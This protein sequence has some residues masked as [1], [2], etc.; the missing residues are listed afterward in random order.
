MT[1]EAQTRPDCWDRQI[2]VDVTMGLSILPL[3]LTPLPPL[4]DLPGHL[5]RYYV[6]LQLQH[7]EALRQ[8]WDFDWHLITNL[9]FDLLVVPLAKAMGLL[10][11]T[12][13]LAALL[14]P[15]M[16]LGFFRVARAVH[17]QAPPTWL[18]AVPFA[19]SFPYHYGFVNFWLSSALALHAFASWIMARERVTHAAV[20]T[21]LLSLSCLLIWLAHLYGW[22]VLVMLVGGYEASRIWTWKL[23]AFPSMVGLVL[24]RSLPV[25]TPVF[26]LGRHA[27]SPAQVSDF[28]LAW[29]VQGLANALRD[30]YFALDL[31]TMALAACL[32][33][34]PL[35]TRKLTFNPRLFITAAVFCVIWMPLPE[36]FLGANHA[37]IRLVPLISAFL[38]LSVGVPGLGAR[39]RHAIAATSLAIFTLRIAADM[40]GFSSYAKEYDRH[41]L[42][43][44]HVEQGKRILVMNGAP[45]WNTWRSPRLDHID[46][47]AIVRKDAFVNSQWAVPGAHLITPKGGKGT[48][49]NKDPSQSNWFTGTCDTPPSLSVRKNL[50][51]IPPDHFDYAWLIGF[52]A[53]TLTTAAS[54]PGFETLYQTDGSLLLRVLGGAAKK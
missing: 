4:R 32:I 13:L 15:L 11:A 14:A 40:V 41:L 46:S 49:F 26:L 53:T 37:S 19:M 17:G 52:D 10:P 51:E 38:I 45:C 43:L 36:V 9:G 20:P 2:A 35:L 12:W 18:A 6:S 7:S 16:I 21:I 1:V 50:L 30:Q 44:N 8:N 27:D 25:F 24:F 39:S 5:G 34:A 23:R 54:T 47:L 3:L 33:T 29:K 31:M 22:V 48:I 28:S 42:A